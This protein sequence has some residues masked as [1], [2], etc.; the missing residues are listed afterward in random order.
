MKVRILCDGN[1]D[2]DEG[3][4][5]AP[6]KQATRLKS[7][8]KTIGSKKEDESEKLHYE[9]YQEYMRGMSKDTLINFIHQKAL[10]R[11]K[12]LIQE[13][14]VDGFDVNRLNT[15]TSCMKIIR[16]SCSQSKI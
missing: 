11:K 5:D 4:K 16:K 7:P 6:I 10:N 2:C 12:A 8:L 3:T 1:V 9:P 15:C 14:S 13:V